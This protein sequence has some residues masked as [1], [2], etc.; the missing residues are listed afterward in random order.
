MTLLA[1]Q[2]LACERDD[3]C[4]FSD[5]DFNVS[6]GDIL[7]IAGANGSGKTTLLRILAGLSGDYTGDLFWQGQALHVDDS[8]YCRQMLYFGHQGAIKSALT[9]EENLRW[10]AQIHG[11]TKTDRATLFAAL[12][13]VG[14]RGFE[15]VPVYSLSAGQKRRVALAR[16]FVAWTPLW[17]LDEP[18]TALD[19]QGVE[20]L[21]NVIVLHAE[22]GGTVLLTT[23]HKLG[24][25]EQRIKVLTLGARR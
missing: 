10:M 13:Q 23:H 8:A 19:R 20:A 24:I 2:G 9:A 21:E 4:L 6:A 25:P 3:R 22:Q 7:Q 18:F 11:H 16:L 14:L 1:A 17:L 5:L 12:G 15:D